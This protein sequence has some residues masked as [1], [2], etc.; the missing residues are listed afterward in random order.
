M[1][2]AIL[3]ARH[4]CTGQVMDGQMNFLN[5]DVTARRD[6]GSPFAIQGLDFGEYVE[7]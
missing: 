7:R 2:F 5:H 6:P 4:A 3:R 1:P